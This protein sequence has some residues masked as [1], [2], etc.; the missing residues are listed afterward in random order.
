MLRGVIWHLF[1]ESKRHSEIKPP[2]IGAVD[3]VEV[4]R[5]VVVGMQVSIDGSMG[6]I[7]PLQS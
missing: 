1:F 7:A 6:P 5:V 2:L 3:V 4:S